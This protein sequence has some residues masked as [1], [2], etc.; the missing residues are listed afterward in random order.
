MAPKVVPT[1]ANP[2][3]CIMCYHLRLNPIRHEGRTFSAKLLNAG[4]RVDGSYQYPATYQDTWKDRTVDD[5]RSGLQT[6][7]YRFA[8]S[9]S[10]DSG[11]IDN[12][13]RLLDFAGQKN[14][15][16]IGLLPPFSPN[17]DRALKTMSSRSSF[18]QE[19]QDRVG[20]SFD[21]RGLEFY[22][23]TDISLYPELQGYGDRFSDYMH[24]KTDLVKIMMDKIRKE[25][26]QLN[27][28]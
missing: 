3:R 20:A 12:L 23:F 24:P 26:K 28:L 4:F 1:T 11:S 17:F 10:V 2:V 27:L 21:E 25:S 6:D 15:S 14:I 19:Y 9:S 7:T 22:N 16:V 13:N 18:Y 5:H 8:A